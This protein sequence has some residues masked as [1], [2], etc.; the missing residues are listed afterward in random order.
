[1]YTNLSYKKISFL[2]KGSL[3]SIDFNSGVNKGL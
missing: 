3:H 1:M 2:S